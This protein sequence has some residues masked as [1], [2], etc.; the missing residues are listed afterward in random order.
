MVQGNKAHL[1]A[2]EEAFFLLKAEVNTKRI[3][4]QFQF[5]SA[6]KHKY[7]GCFT[8]PHPR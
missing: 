8:L 3:N 4:T 7:N 2:F 5:T 6:W 1:E